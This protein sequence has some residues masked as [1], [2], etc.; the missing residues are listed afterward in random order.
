VGGEGEVLLGV[1]IELL[2]TLLKLAGAVA[3]VFH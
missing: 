1:G 3:D 2:H